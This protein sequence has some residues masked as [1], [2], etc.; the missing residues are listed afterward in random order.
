MHKYLQ[1]QLG[2][3]G[4]LV[5][6][7]N[8]YSAI[9]LMNAGH[10]LK[11][12]THVGVDGTLL[13]RI[14]GG[15]GFRSSADLTVNE[16]MLNGQYT[17]GLI[18]G[19]QESADAHMRSFNAKFADSTVLW[20]INGFDNVLP[21][22]TA[23]LNR[24]VPDLILIGMGAGPQETVAEQ[25]WSRDDVRAHGCLVMTC[26][27]WLDQLE[28]KNYYPK[29]AY[30]LRLNWLVR[31][32]REPRRLWRRYTLHAFWALVNHQSIKRYVSQHANL[33][34]TPDRDDSARAARLDR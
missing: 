11:T 7:L 13:L 3:H 22:V 34:L 28:F 12:F 15:R 8:H 27:G 33:W 29:W 9:A 18:G 5:T 4:A 16:I 23:A 17:V 2:T 26:G 14:V 25:I 24:A 32:I 21:N 1:A 10:D 6:W 31:L 20:S 30:P 19:S